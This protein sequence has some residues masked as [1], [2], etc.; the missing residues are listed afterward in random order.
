MCCP[1]V[2]NNI[3]LYSGGAFKVSS[4]NDVI[5]AVV[6]HRKVYSRKTIDA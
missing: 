2:D 6:D 1:Y 4:R 3:R 5:S